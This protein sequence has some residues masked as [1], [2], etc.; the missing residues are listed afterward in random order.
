[1]PKETPTRNDSKEAVFGGQIV[2]EETPVVQLQ[3]PYNINPALVDTLTT[4]SG[5]IA[6]VDSVAEL[7]TGAAANSRA[8]LF[9]KR[10]AAYYP[11]QG[12]SI[13]FTTR[14]STGVEGNTQTMGVGDLS[15]GYAVGMFG[16]DFGIRRRYGGAKETRT[17]KITAG[18]TN[19]GNV[20]ITINGTAQVVPVVAGESF[21]EIAWTMAGFDYSAF[22]EGWETIYDGDGV[23]FRSYDNGEK[24]GTFSFVDTDATGVTMTIVRDLVGVDANDEIITQ[25]DFNQN[26]V[27]WLDPTKGNVYRIRYQW[28]GYGKILYEVEQPTL[29]IFVPMHI[30][31]YANENLIP[32][33]QNP[34]LPLCIES[35]NTT[36][37]TDVTI[38]TASAAI[39]V[40]GRIKPFEVLHSAAI[41]NIT[42]STDE[43]PLISLHNELDFQGKP[44]RVISK[45][46][47]ISISADGA[48]PV[49]FTISRGNKLI[50][51]VDL[52]PHDEDE[53]IM[54]IDTSATGIEI[55]DQDL[56]TVLDKTGSRLVILDDIINIF[57]QSGETLSISAHTNNGSNGSVS[58]T[59]TWKE[60]F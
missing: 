32:S 7:S 57:I 9:S 5:S 39:F 24:D 33:T 30:I 52:N 19:S 3:F 4:G 15:D 48:Q 59:V 45:I 11:G 23:H 42:V 22:D 31:T 44:N 14:F 17:F 46:E 10:P 38:G 43:V 27:S 54:E 50:G 49:F 29:G 26:K 13:K 35:H 16:S 18:A 40:E 47:L 2:A 1:M 20:T 58:V 60:L 51:P 56:T 37:T 55:T 53:S 25:S 28:L 36:N 21:G 12:Q 34:T 8:I 41:E 6:V